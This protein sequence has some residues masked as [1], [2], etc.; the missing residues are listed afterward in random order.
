[1]SIR[2][3]VELFFSIPAAW[4]VGA[5]FLLTCAEASL[6]FGFVIP[7]EIAVVLGGVLASRETVPLPAVIAAAIGGAVVGD[8][9]GFLVGR[10]WGTAILHRFFPRRWPPVGLWLDRRG[11]PAVFFGRSTAFL[12]AVVPTA[13]GAAR[14]VPARFFVWNVAGGVV[15]GA[16]FSLLGYFAGEGYEA[17]MR[18][19]GRGSLAFVT[20]LGCLALFF[21]AKHA[22]I[23]RIAQDQGDA[24]PPVA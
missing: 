20:L 10:R 9:I 8:A 15:W 1:L 3:L 17:A 18:V 11:A 14:M 23:R 5:V 4:A 24:G 6:F 19:A 22:I 7:G 2:K 16:G 12:R 21:V 13:A